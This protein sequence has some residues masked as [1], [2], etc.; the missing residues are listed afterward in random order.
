MPW[1][2]KN[3]AA[4]DIAPDWLQPY[5]EQFMQQLADQGYP[6]ASASGSGCM[7]GQGLPEARSG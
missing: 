1:K 2:I 5:C 6:S 4:A 3:P 7:I